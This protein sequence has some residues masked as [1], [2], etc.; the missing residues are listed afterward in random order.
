MSHEISI[1]S[2]LLLSSASGATAQSLPLFL[3]APALPVTD[4]GRLDGSFAFPGSASC[5]RF[6]GSVW[7]GATLGRAAPLA[8]APTLP[9]GR[10]VEAGK[11]ALSSPR[12]Q[13]RL[14]VDART[15]TVYG[16]IRAYV[17]I[18]TR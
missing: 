9:A 8:L 14:S 16:P 1:A 5:V 13:A 4:C 3:S 15:E 10:V 7:A 2:L 18:R 6:G 17:S 11:T 12:L